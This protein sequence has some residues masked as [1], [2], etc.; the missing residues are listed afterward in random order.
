MI[1]EVHER[2]LCES[3]RA[4]LSQQHREVSSHDLLAAVA[5]CIEATTAACWKTEIKS[6]LYGILF[7]FCL[8][9]RISVWYNLISAITEFLFNEL[10]LYIPGGL[11]LKIRDSL[12]PTARFFQAC[13]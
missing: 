7:F 8:D 9:D 2:E 3:H 13:D 6:E 10:L 5:A 12:P 11:A 4:A 1:Q